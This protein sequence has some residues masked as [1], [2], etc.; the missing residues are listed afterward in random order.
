MG[1]HRWPT[2]PKG[3]A[4]AHNKTWDAHQAALK[5]NANPAKPGEVKISTP[6]GFI[7]V[8]EWNFGGTTSAPDVKPTGSSSVPVSGAPAASAPNGAAPLPVDAA[9]DEQMGALGSTRDQALAANTGAR[10]RGLGEYGFTESA[11][12]PASQTMGALAFDPNNPFSKAALLKKSYDVGRAK[13]GQSMGSQG[14]LYSG[15]YQTAQDQLNRN[16]LQG[17]DTLTKSLSQ[18]LASNSG[19]RTQAQTN[20]ELGAGQAEGD[21]VSRGLSNPLY[22]P[23]LDPGPLAPTIA[24][25][26]GG[27]GSIGTA[28]TQTK[29]PKQ[30]LTI[31][32]GPKVRAT[33]NTTV[34]KPRKGKTVTYTTSVKGP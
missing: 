4:P 26:T 10:T 19:Q 7:P 20:F 3:K 6:N 14:Q 30:P 31:K 2:D 18:F 12:D 27:V 32:A 1:L 16:Q 28:V 8:S 9:F 24:T 29:K 25:P 21:R 23:V 33:K 13:T 17:E 11:F 22:T 5:A 34:T 15:A